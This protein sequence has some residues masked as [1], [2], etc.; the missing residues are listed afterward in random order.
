M[1]AEPRGS[2]LVKETT[3]LL[4]WVGVI[5]LALLLAACGATPGTTTPSAMDGMD[6]NAMQRMPTMPAMDHSSMPMSSADV[7]FEAMFIDSMIV[8]HEGAIAMANQV[9]DEAEKPELKTLAQNIITAQESEVK[10]LK[11][12]RAEWF[13][14]LPTT[15]GTGMAMGDMQISDD[16][17]IPFDQRFITA[18]IA[19]HDGAVAMAKDAQQKAERPEIKTLADNI[20]TA[21]ESEIAQ[22]RQWQQEWYGN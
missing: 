10:Q 8:H 16:A 1:C 15:A 22:M 19:H 13:P 21:Q 5:A 12:W 20:I 14:G 17:S 6:N 2:A 9:L 18:M 7:P 11:Q 4:R 3:V